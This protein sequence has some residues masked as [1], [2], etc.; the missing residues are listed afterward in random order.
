MTADMFDRADAWGPAVGYGYW[1]VIYAE[2][3]DA[4]LAYDRIVAAMPA[5]AVRGRLVELRPELPARLA[6]VARLAEL[7]AALYPAWPERDSTLLDL[8][9]EDPVKDLRDGLG[10][11]LCDPGLRDALLDAREELW[12]VAEDAAQL[13]VRLWENPSATD[14]PT[15]LTGLAAGVATALPTG[16]PVGYLTD[17]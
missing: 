6:S 4:V 16:I 1:R 2:C 3:C 7:A 17:E 10:T 9:A 13:A 12:R 8:L 15:W 11:G 5:G 14:V